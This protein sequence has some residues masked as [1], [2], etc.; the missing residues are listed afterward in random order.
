MTS[1]TPTSAEQPQ[2][3]EQA[4]VSLHGVYMFV[5]RNWA[6][7]ASDIPGDRAKVQNALRKLERTGLLASTHVNGETALTWQSMYDVENEDA[8]EAKAEASFAAMYPDGEPQESSRSTSG[9]RR[10]PDAGA[11]ALNAEFAA[12][13]QRIADAA[14]LRSKY[15]VSEAAEFR[16]LLASA[17]T[18]GG[19]V[20][21]E[22]RE[23]DGA[24]LRIPVRAL[25]EFVASGDKDT[26]AKLRPL[27][28]P[29]KLIGRKLAIYALVAAQDKTIREALSA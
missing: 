8:A 13:A 3:A 23:E 27:S 6:V 14:G 21:I 20:Q 9:P 26:A 12:A 24:V 7:L 22:R 5:V 29:P 4:D 11:D 16:L 18:K 1:I 28:C 2:A 15:H 17:M 19:V 10:F 25:R